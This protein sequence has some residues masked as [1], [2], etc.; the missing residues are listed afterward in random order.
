M[1]HADLLS[2]VGQFLALPPDLTDLPGRLCGASAGFSGSIGWKPT[3]ATQSAAHWRVAGNRGGDRRL[4]QTGGCRFCVADAGFSTGG[5]GHS[6]GWLRSGWRQQRLETDACYRKC[7][8]LAHRRRVPV[9]CSSRRLKTRRRLGF[10]AVGGS[11]GW[12]PTPATQ[13]AAHW[14][15]A[16]KGAGIGGWPNRRVPVLYGRRRVFNRRLLFGRRVVQHPDA[17][18]RQLHQHL[19]AHRRRHVGGTA[20]LPGDCAKPKGN[21]RVRAHVDRRLHDRRHL[22]AVCGI[23]H[24]VLGAHGYHHWP[25]GQRRRSGLQLPARRAPWTPGY[26]ASDREGSSRC[27][28]TWLPPRSLAARRTPAAVQTAGGVRQTTAPPGRP[29]SRPPPGRG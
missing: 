10:A 15:V 7:C 21:L 27:G 28:R 29:A 11:I 17:P 4:G 19:A 16:G 8:A 20:C 23:E 5:C 2:F 25:V 9:S 18:R 26:R 22:V 13:S 6:R 14:R 3:P 1:C 12:K 24:D